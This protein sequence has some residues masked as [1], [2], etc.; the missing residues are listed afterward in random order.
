MC[1]II[2]YVNIYPFSYRRPS[3]WRCYECVLSC[4]LFVSGSCRV[5]PLPN[6]SQ[7]LQ[8][9]RMEPTGIRDV[10]WR[11]R[12][13]ENVRHLEMPASNPKRETNCSL[14]MGFK[15]W[16]TESY[17]VVTPWQQAMKIGTEE[18][19][20]SHFRRWA[21]TTLLKKRNLLVAV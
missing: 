16:R 13:H 21:C 1:W 6:W 2:I 14:S 19:L 12:L 18:L 10:H 9:R 11:G 5:H 4:P 17:H 15:L 3:D 8:I 7:N 20:K